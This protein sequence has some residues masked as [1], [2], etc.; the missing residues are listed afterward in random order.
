MLSQI[1]LPIAATLFCYGLF[2]VVQFL[3]H[4]LTSPLRSMVGPRNPSFVLGN[5]NEMMDD[6]SLPAQW[7][8][9]FGR[10]FRF[11][12]LFSISELHSSDIKAV[13]HI[14]SKS[15]IY[16]RLPVNQDFL[17]RLL[18]EGILSAQV[19]EHKRQV[20][21]SNN[22]AFG[23]AQIR[24]L[25]EVLIDKGVQLRDLWAHKIAQG[26]GAATIDVLEWLRRTTLDVIG[27]AGFHY[28]FD[29]LHEKGQSNELN[30]AFTQLLHSPHSQRDAGFRRAQSIIPFLK[31]LP[32]PGTRNRRKTRDTMNSIGRQIISTSKDSLMASQREKT[33]SKRDLLSV[34]LKAN[35]SSDLPESQR[36]SDAEVIARRWRCFVNVCIR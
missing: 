27:Q 17:K 11:K 21:V 24:L 33:D 9:E 6:A 29:A 4:E 1:L 13:N 5:F 28:E 20:S 16:R 26:N 25:T 31:L 15:T 18:G 32:V 10:T 7:R 23:V 12:G 35:L 3:Y 34:L 36:L 14:V 22:Q 2:H 19:D 8:S 30:K